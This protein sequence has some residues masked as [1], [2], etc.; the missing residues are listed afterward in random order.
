MTKGRP[1]R[2]PSLAAFLAFERHSMPPLIAVLHNLGRDFTGHAGVAI[3]AAGLELD[4]RRLRA[5][6]GLPAL[7]EIDGVRRWAATSRS[8]ESRATRC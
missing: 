6:E 1:P 2:S 8:A 4:E 7:D 5:G 3:R